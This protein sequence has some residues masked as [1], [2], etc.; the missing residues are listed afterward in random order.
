M[1]SLD[2]QKQAVWFT[3]IEEVQEGIDTIKRYSKPEKHDFTVSSTSGTPEEIAAGIV[4][5]YDRYITSYGRDFHPQEGDGIF[6]D[7]TPELDA[8]GNL[9]MLNE[10]GE[11]DPE[12]IEPKTPPDYILKKII[13]TLR[14][15]VARYGIKKEGLESEIR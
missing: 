5:N 8:D 3:R 1:R 13:D 10:A 14:G 4:P 11:V 7:V 9:V 12:G 2:R 6:V 15:T